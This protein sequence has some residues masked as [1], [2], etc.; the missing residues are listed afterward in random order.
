MNRNEK[1]Q[2]VEELN[3]TL[4]SSESVVVCHYKGLTVKDITEFRAQLRAEGGTFKVTKNTLAKLA[5]EG[6]SYEGLKDLFTGPTGIAVSNDPVAAAKVAYNFAKENNNLVILGGGL[7]TKVLDVAG[8]EALAK[9]PSLD[10]VRAKL[11]ALLV[12]PATKIA[13]VVAAPAVQLVNVTKA[14]GETA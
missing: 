4:S 12:A 1:Q 9:L 11:A 8:V 14:Q 3:S 7:G 5:S 10:E 13:R 6:T 2:A